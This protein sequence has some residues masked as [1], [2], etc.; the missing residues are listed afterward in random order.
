MKQIPIQL[1]AT[2]IAEII[3]LLQPYAEQ[4]ARLYLSIEGNGWGGYRVVP[5][6]CVYDDAPGN[7][8]PNNLAGRR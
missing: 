2:P 4:H 1:D 7:Y 3:K 8:D 5:R 6:I